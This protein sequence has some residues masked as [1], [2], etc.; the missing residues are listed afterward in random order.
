MLRRGFA[1]V[2]ASVIIPTRNRTEML[3][4]LLGQLASQIASVDHVVEVIV[5]DNCPEASARTV[6]DQAAVAIPQLIYL[7]VPDPGVVQA[8]NA[9]VMAA[10]GDYVIFLDDDEM[11][12]PNWLASWLQQADTGVEAAFGSVRPSYEADPALKRGILDRMFS[13]SFDAPTGTDVTRHLVRLGCGNSMILRARLDGPRPFDARFNDTGGED[14][15][16]IGQLAQRGARLIWNREAAV[17][18]IVPASRMSVDYMKRR[19]FNQARLRCLLLLRSGRVAAW[20]KVAFWMA[21]GLAQTILNSGRWLFARGP[22]RQQF[23]I[24]MQGGLGKLLWYRGTDAY[25]YATPPATSLNSSAR[26]AQ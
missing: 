12:A 18:E 15:Q 19:R 4:P 17:H 23:E 7:H 21:V 26:S 22:Q 5:A 20:P 8:R 11:P 1:A 9:G 13:R 2:R 3:A 24:K 6:C 10:A 14:L 16:L 25:L